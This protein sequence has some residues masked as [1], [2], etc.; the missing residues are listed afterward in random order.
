MFDHIF[1]IFE[2]IFLG[3]TLDIFISIQR[4]FHQ[5]FQLIFQLVNYWI[6]VSWT[7]PPQDVLVPILVLR[8]L[9]W[10]CKTHRVFLIENLTMV[11]LQY[12]S[13][14]FANEINFRQQNFSSWCSKSISIFNSDWSIKSAFR[15]GTSPD[16]SIH[17]YLNFW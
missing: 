12:W 7:R 14:V 16:I 8:R 1:S 4:I 15:I 9:E 6:L 2:K 11:S 10:N 13:E 3:T 17:S 5:S